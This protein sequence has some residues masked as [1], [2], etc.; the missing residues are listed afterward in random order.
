MII[1][2]WILWIVM[3]GAAGYFTVRAIRNVIE[4]RRITKQINYIHAL[5]DEVE[6]ALG[7]EF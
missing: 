3:W 7:E 6:K 5:C 1:L 2:A 4:C